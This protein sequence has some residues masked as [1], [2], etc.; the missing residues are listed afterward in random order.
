MRARFP[1]LMVNNNNYN[2]GEN[3]GSVMIDLYDNGKG[4][5]KLFDR[6]MSTGYDREKTRIGYDSY[7]W[8]QT[9]VRL[10]INKILRLIVTTEKSQSRL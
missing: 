2:Y 4:L 8:K 1:N 6:N 5:T 9:Q 3:I 10:T 7:Q